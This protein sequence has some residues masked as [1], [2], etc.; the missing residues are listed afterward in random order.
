MP[1]FSM[2]R[3]SSAAPDG[4]ALS[5]PNADHV[6][7][8]ERLVDAPREA[9]WHALVG[10]TLRDLPVAGA[11]MKLRGVGGPTEGESLLLHGPIPAQ[12]VHPPATAIG[13]VAHRPWARRHG[14]PVDPHSVDDVGD[15]WIVTFTE[16]RLD[17]VGPSR[18]RVTTQ[19]RCRATSSDARRRMSL[20]WAIVGPFSALVRREIL[21]AVARKAERAS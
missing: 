12:E 16:F 9:V 19:T 5:L 17:A 10:L 3:R 21:R 1:F 7:W 4:L 6:E 18:T 15:G 14:P 13:F 8:H 11:L 2:W 20:Y